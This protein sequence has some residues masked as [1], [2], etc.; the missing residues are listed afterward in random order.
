MSRNI[1]DQNRITKEI[2]SIGPFEQPEIILKHTIGLI[3]FSRKLERNTKYPYYFEYTMKSEAPPFG[4]EYGTIFRKLSD[5]LI[6]ESKVHKDPSFQDERFIS[7]RIYNKDFI[8]LKKAL[9]KV[10][11]WF[12]ND[13]F[14]NDVNG[15]IVD[16]IPSARELKS[17]SFSQF[18]ANSSY[19]SFQPGLVFDKIN[20]YPGVHIKT[21]KGLLGSVSYDEFL[22][23]KMNL[24]EYMNN[25]NS[26]S[27]Q[28]LQLAYLH[29]I[30]LPEDT[31]P[32]DFK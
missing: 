32:M 30:G 27:L 26:F 17:I 4:K 14:I 16:L 13:L 6:L 10:V 9:N 15:K 24:D 12:K 22:L 5:C 19:L 28:M 25:F 31:N 23:L 7:Y 20:T 8:E 21:N 11:E 18:D 1:K 3:R 29:N 2:L